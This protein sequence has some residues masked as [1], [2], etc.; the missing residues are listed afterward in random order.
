MSDEGYI[1]YGLS[2]SILLTTLFLAYAIKDVLK[3]KENEENRSLKMLLKI[4]G[5]E[6]S[7]H[8]DYIVAILTATAAKFQSIAC[9]RYGTLLIKACYEAKGKDSK[10]HLS[11]VF[12]IANCLSA[13]L[14]F[15]FGLLSDKIKIYKLIGL[16]GFVVVLTD[17]WM[18]FLIDKGVE[19]LD[20]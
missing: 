3:T 15:I 1:Y 12:L 14:P 10:S 18:I 8:P 9:N 7:T 2:V 13:I 20:K 4:V 11:F 19:T 16:V 17:I 6:F 5:K